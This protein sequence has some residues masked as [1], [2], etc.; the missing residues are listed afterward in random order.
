MK[1]SNQKSW[2]NAKEATF[3]IPTACI[4][5]RGAMCALGCWFVCCHCMFCSAIITNLMKFNYRRLQFFFPPT[6]HFLTRT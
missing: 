6:M 3:L 5:H 2:K 4:L 1:C